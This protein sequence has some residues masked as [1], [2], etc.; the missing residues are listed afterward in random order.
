MAT[1]IRKKA[2]KSPSK[3]LLLGSPKNI[4]IASPMNLAISA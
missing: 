2:R 4:S 3:P 1:A